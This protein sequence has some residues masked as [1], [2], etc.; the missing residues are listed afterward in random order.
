MGETPAYLSELTVQDKKIGKKQVRIDATKLKSIVAEHTEMTLDVIKA[1]PDLLNDPILVLDS[2]TVKG[3]LVLLG[4]VYANGK[5]VMMAIEI[6]P[7]T[8][9]GSA[10]Y[11]DVIKVASAYTR[12]NTQALIDTSN[13]RY[14]NE[15][16]SRVDDWL[17]VNRLQLPLPNSQSDSAVEKEQELLS[18]NSISE[19]SENV[20]RE[21]EKSFS[22]FSDRYT[23]DSLVSKPD[24]KVTRIDESKT[25]KSRADIVVDAKKNA[26]KIG[27]KHADG[28]ISVYVKDAQKSVLLS[29]SG[30][31]HGLDRRLS[32]NGA[33]TVMAGE[34]IANSIVINELIS[35]NEK[36][37]ESYVLI[38]VA[39]DTSG[40]IKIVESIVNRFNNELI[41]L[42]VLYSMNA[43]QDDIKGTAALNAPS[44]FN[45][46]YRS[47]ISIA[48]LL[49][50]VNRYFPDVLPED[51][52]KHYGYD[53]RPEGEIGKSALYSERE[54]LSN[55]TLLANALETVAKNET[56]RQK[57]NEYK[58]KIGLMEQDEARLSEVRKKIKELSREKGKSDTEKIQSLQNTKRKIEARILKYDRQLFR[59]EASEA[60]RKVLYRELNNYRRRAAE[61]RNRTAARGE[62]KKIVAELNAYLA[63][64]KVL[65]GMQKVVAEALDAINMDTVGADARVAKYD[66]LIKKTTDPEMREELIKTRN[67]IA[68]QGESMQGKLQKLKAAYADIINSSDPLIANSHDEVIEGK[69][70]DVI[71]EVGDTAIRDMSITQL[72]AVYDLYKMILTSVR[73]A[74]KAFR[75][76]KAK[77]I[78][79][80]ASEVMTQA[81]KT[82]G[83]RGK[84]SKV[85]EY[86]TK[87]FGWDNLKPIYAMRMI[88][89]DT[90]TELYKNV[91][92]GQS[93]WYKDFAAARD[94]LRAQKKAY[95]VSKW[96]YAK[97]YTFTSESGKT[98]DMTLEQILSLYAYS[99]R[100]QAIDHLTKGGI[101]FDDAIEVVEKNKLGIPMK[102][103]VNDK[104]AYRLSEGTI[105]EIL[106]TLTEEQKAYADIMQSYLS[107]V[108]GEKGNEVSLAMYGVKLFKEKNYFPLKS[109]GQFL[110]TENEVKGEA[111]IKNAGFTK[112]TI[113]RANNPI[114]LSN[115]TDVWVGHCNEMSMY[116]AFTL[117]LEDFNRVWQYKARGGGEDVSVRTTLANTCG[118]AANTY[119]KDLLVELNGGVRVKDAGVL[120]KLTGLAKKGAVFASA[121]VTIQQP[122]AIC[123]A[124]AYISPKYFLKTAKKQLNF[125]KHAETWEECKKYAPIAGIKEMGYFDTGMGR[126]S[127]EWAKSEE[128]EGFRNK[129]KAFFKDGSYR[130][131]VLSRAPALA[132]E[133]TWCHIWNATKAW[134]ADTTSLVGEELLAEAGKRFT[135]VIDLTQVYDSV[136]SRSANMR[137]KNSLMKMATAFMAEPTT[138]AN[139]ML[140]AFVNGKRTGGA[141]GAGIVAKA[142]V[143]VL[144]S[145]VLNS[146]L[147]AVVYAWRDDDDEKSYLE[148]YGESA[149][150][151]FLDD[152]N[153]FNYIPVLRDIVSLFQ[154]Y[155]VSRL[156]MSLF[157]DLIRA[158]QS[159]DSS[160]K[161][162]YRKVSDI[163]GALAKFFGLPIKNIDRDLRPLIRKIFG[164]F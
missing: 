122:S 98:F 19:N 23:Y 120:D 20:N 95:G 127:L 13:I 119:I 139:M 69:L 150:G 66:E 102:Y 24:M 99:K 28:G 38:G 41:S 94:F 11:V 113:P 73:Q 72:E 9:S 33:V 136:L 86:I 63:E 101:V 65:I 48:Q 56:E 128:Y 104:S 71:C 44:V 153:P 14:V 126:S 35:K 60:L 109:S 141:K 49:E 124:M 37:A 97:K 149:L 92:E 164:A 100:P 70:D 157:E 129:L 96:D 22:K 54:D 162:P 62:V 105:T 51:V 79:W 130:D 30:L 156:D 32:Q 8:R 12:R 50:Y 151:S 116:H 45:P 123:R 163:I 110:Y 52:L 88:G 117:P 40:A 77:T 57:L 137:N 103:T 125:R 93:V 134:V 67:R 59:L 6:N 26:A 108:M 68:A 91:R 75:L 5:P 25:P 55:R 18:T 107:E 10:T 74:N 85:W 154:G 133:I 82:H 16:K 89:S 47:T 135:D 106:N 132:D 80:Y 152:I 42:D 144:A 15:N 7:T 53:A 78:D 158:L 4:E 31:V 81:E 115:F 46:N 84:V 34:I 159:I 2:K 155:D 138:T 61:G 148:K 27:A 1:L 90:L 29:K 87:N 17:K 147:K 118:D 121:S 140:D 143:A 146:L 112:S 111:K 39:Q 131:D 161:S 83:T 145:I 43:K 160:R 21:S 114:I 64:N 76:D 58:T 142:G 36:A 3:R